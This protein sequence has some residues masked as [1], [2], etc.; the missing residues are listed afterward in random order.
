MPAVA[1]PL[2]DESQ[3]EAERIARALRSGDA[4]LI[5]PLVDRYQYRLVRYLVYVTGRRDLVDDL[6]Q[7]TW[8]RV[9]ARGCQ[10]DRRARFET[11]L[12]SIARNLAVDGLRRR[13]RRDAAE[14]GAFIAAPENVSPFLAAARGEDAA[15]LAAALSRL[16]PEY[17]E[18]LLL[19]FQEDL[20]LREI[21]AV[22]GAPLSTVSSRVHRGLER[23]RALWKGDTDGE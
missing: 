23:L 1:M 7:E 2:P 21:A 16:E 5:G 18:A 11:W 10:Y 19:R 14:P 4:A 17:R 9:I 13:Q 12:F 20:S 15:R 22:V 6:A 8:L 3:A